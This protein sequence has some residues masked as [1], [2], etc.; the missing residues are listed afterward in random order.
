MH[1][2]CCCHYLSVVVVVIDFNLRNLTLKFGQNQSVIDE[3]LL[4]LFLICYSCL[5]IS[6]VHVQ[7]TTV[8]R[9]CYVVLL[10]GF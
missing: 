10:L 2:C 7:P 3:M 8:L 9:L 6:H 4:L 1:C 5:I